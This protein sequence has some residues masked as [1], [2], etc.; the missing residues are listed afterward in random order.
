MSAAE[1]VGAIAEKGPEDPNVPGTYSKRWKAKIGKELDTGKR[2]GKIVRNLDDRT[3]DRIFEILA[4]EEN[5]VIM[6]SLGDID[7]QSKVF[8]K[9]LYHNP[10]LVSVLSRVIPG[11]L[12]RKGKDIW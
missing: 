4:R 3:I 8:L 12:L 6:E 5:R 2:I 11:T 7:F 9:L 1:L 10:A